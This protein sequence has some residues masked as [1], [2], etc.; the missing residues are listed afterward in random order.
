MLR[1]E[2]YELPRAIIPSPLFFL[3]F[4]ANVIAILY[5]LLGEAGSKRDSGVASYHV[6]G[7]V[8]NLED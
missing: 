7:Y 8:D 5:Y 6:I 2:T 3:E 1:Y 4:L